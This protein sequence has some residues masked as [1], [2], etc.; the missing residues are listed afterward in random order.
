M[1]RIVTGPAPYRLPTLIAAAFLFA[2][3]GG[4][5]AEVISARGLGIEIPSGWEPETPSSNMR[6]LQARVPGAGGDGEFLVFHFGVGGGGGV[7]ANI[8]RWIGQLELAA[9]S[10]P[11]REELSVGSL[12][13]HTVDVSGTLKA[14]R[15][16]SFP[17]TD[18]PGY[19]LL[20]AIVEG[21]GGP[22]FLRLVAPGATAAAERDA[23]ISMLEGLKS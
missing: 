18:L 21:E 8:E 4:V 2:V 12:R 15:I 19:R 23:F 22:W 17:S 1:I 9:G 10:G 16:G 11:I 5:A 13:V 7:E 3:G 20:G 6:L 14:S